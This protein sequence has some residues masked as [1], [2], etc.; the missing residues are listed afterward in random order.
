MISFALSTSH[1]VSCRDKTIKRLVFSFKHGVFCRSE[2]VYR[3]ICEKLTTDVQIDLLFQFLGA[4]E[5]I[6]MKL[7]SL[8]KAAPTFRAE[9]LRILHTNSFQHSSTSLFH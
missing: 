9:D 1:S 8:M 2:F 7:S 3:F 5:H 4:A 6:N